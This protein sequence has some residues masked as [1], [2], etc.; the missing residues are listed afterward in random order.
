MKRHG[1]AYVQASKSVEKNKAYT[2][3]EADRLYAE[4]ECDECIAYKSEEN[5]QQH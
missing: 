2:P 4:Y 3:E 5:I 1:K